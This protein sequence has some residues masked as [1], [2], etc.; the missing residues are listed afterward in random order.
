[1]YDQSDPGSLILIRMFTKERSIRCVPFTCVPGYTCRDGVLYN[2]YTCLY[3]NK[4]NAC[5]L[6]G[7]S[8]KVYCAG[9]PMEK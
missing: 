2:N 5:A 7:Q 8:A 1:M 6:I 4:I 3:N 9:K